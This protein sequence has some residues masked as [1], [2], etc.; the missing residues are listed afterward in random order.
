MKV[1]TEKGVVDTTD[2]VLNEWQRKFSNLYNH[3]PNNSEYDSTF[4]TSVTT[5]HLAFS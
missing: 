5:E 4:L 3:E 1:N 2:E